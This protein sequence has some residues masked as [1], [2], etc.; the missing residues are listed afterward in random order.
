MVR[1]PERIISIV[2]VLVW[3]KMNF[4]LAVVVNFGTHV[5][6]VSKELCR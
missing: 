6:T 5:G 2:Y 4:S 1:I 3:T